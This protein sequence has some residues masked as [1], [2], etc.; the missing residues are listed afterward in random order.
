M[1]KNELIESGILETYVLGLSTS[2]EKAQVEKLISDDPEIRKEKEE[3]EAL[4]ELL[5]QAYAI[6]PPSQTQIKRRIEGELFLRSEEGM[7]ANVKP[8][9]GGGSGQSDSKSW[10]WLSIAASVSLLIMVF[11][12]YRLNHRVETAENQ[13]AAARLESVQLL[14]M[15][16]KLSAMGDQ[17]SRLT[18]TIGEEGTRQVILTS[19]IQQPTK[20]IVFWNPTNHKVWLVN[21]NLPQLPIDKQY[22]LWGIVDGKPV[23]A[24]VFDANSGDR[25]IAIE[26]KSIARPQVLAVTVE[27]RGG[28]SSPT[29]STLCLKA[30][31]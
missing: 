27:N 24:G 14:E 29:L 15:N 22:Q 7:E 10:M 31:I 8:L 17:F 9:H 23:D 25:A 13:L 2:E 28:V 26:L 11:Y 21:T 5:A 6:I 16:K 19:T 20:A 1:E 30:E 12:G 18:S 4:L 3:I